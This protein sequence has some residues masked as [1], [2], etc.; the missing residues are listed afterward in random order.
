MCLCI[1]NPAADGR[2]VCMCMYACVPVPIHMVKYEE[3]TVYVPMCD[4][5]V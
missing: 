5:L 3:K 1:W 4:V 2:Y